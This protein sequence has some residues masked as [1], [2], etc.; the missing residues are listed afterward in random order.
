MRDNSVG[1]ASLVLVIIGALNWGLTGLGGFMNSNWNVVELIL[2]SVP[3]VE[4]LVYL[5][6][7]L[8]GVYEVYRVA[9]QM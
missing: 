3:V 2:G 5:L 7:G 8:A 6:V 4:N 1:M 9:E